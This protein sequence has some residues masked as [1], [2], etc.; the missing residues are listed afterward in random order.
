MFGLVDPLRP[1]IAEAVKQC[2]ISGITVRMCTG[3]NINTA[4]AISLEAGIL[5]K[6]SK[7]NKAKLHHLFPWRANN[8]S[9]KLVTLRRLLMMMVKKLRKFRMLINLRKS[10]DNSKLWLV[11]A[12][13]TNMSSLPA[14]NN[15]AE[16][17]Q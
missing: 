7:K 4:K 5:R 17:S 16:P 6:T 3:D 13:T 15:W 1:G 8:L 10:L 11:A 9:G 14:L 2:N 12:L